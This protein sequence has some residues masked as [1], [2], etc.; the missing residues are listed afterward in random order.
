MAI[1]EALT[2]HSGNLDIS[3]VFMVIGLMIFTIFT[4]WIEILES[5]TQEVIWGVEGTL[6]A[7]GY[8]SPF[9]HD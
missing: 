4:F 5:C 3:E 6:L 7:L 2:V 9:S 8:I 1:S